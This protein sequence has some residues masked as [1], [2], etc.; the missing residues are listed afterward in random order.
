MTTDA[1]DDADNDANDDNAINVLLV[2][3]DDFNDDDL[4]NCTK[5]IPIINSVTKA[6][7]STLTK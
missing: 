3:N 1:I 6:K 4:S 2:T 5:Y 7:L